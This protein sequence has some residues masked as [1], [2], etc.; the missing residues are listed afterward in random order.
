[1]SML[2]SKGM[3]LEC[4]KVET[5][6]DKKLFINMPWM[7]YKYDSTWVPPLKMALSDMLNPKHPF[8]ETGTVQCF[9]AFKDRDVVGRIMAI[10]PRAYNDYHQSQA[11][12]FGFFES[13]NDQEVADLLLQTAE[14]WIKEQGLNEIQGPFNLSSNYE[15]GLLVKGFDDPPQIMMT[16]NPK[17]YPSFFDKRDYK[18]AMDLLAYNVSYPVTMP[19]IILK[20]V[21]RAEKKSRITY[22][23]FNK[24]D[25]DQEIKR[26][27][28]IYNDAWEKNWGFV[29]MTEKEFKHTA[30]DLKM[31]LNEKLVLFVEVDGETAGFIVGLPDLHQVFKK[32]PTGS[33]LPTGIFKILNFKKHITRM[34]V[35]T[36]GVKQKYRRLGLETLLYR[37][38]QQEAEKT[39]MFTHCEASWILEDNIN[40][41]RPLQRMGFEAYKTYRIYQ[42]S[43]S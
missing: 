8:Y 42:K 17:Y 18:K 36:M 32:I 27:F 10:N 25:F 7:I 16:Y 13:T 26:M 38:C 2:S 28:E 40:M 11:G 29:P 20:I 5:S 23:Y 12:F 31:I 19:E 4:R 35:P 41:N 33:L 3:G 14:D 37:K 39:G 21:D 43:L 6:K 15:S 22:R 1:M 34:R 9:L 30:K 24:K